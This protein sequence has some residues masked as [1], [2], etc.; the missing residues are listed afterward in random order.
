MGANLFLWIEAII[1]F[2][3]GL[4]LF[5]DFRKY[6]EGIF[7]SLSLVFFF[8]VIKSII[9][10]NIDFF[11]VF[12]VYEET[13]PGMGSYVTRVFKDLRPLYNLKEFMWQGIET[14]FLISLSFT[15]MIRRKSVDVENPRGLKAGMWVQIL[16]VTLIV[17]SVVGISASSHHG[18]KVKLELQKDQKQT[19]K[20]VKKVVVEQREI[21]ID[22]LTDMSVTKSLEEGKEYEY[23]VVRSYKSDNA[24]IE[25]VKGP[26]GKVM[27]VIWKIVLMILTLLSITSI[28]GYVANQ[29]AYFSRNKRLMFTF[30]F[31]QMAFYIFSTFVPFTANPNWFILDIIAIVLFATFGYKVHLQ[32]INNIEAQVES[33]G[34]ERDIIIDLMRDISGIVGSGNF[35]LDTV[36]KEIV[37]SSVKGSGARAG[38]V[39]IKDPL[40]NRLMVKYV[41]GLYPPTKPIKA[42]AGMAMNESII[43]EK[44]RSEKIMLGEGLLGEVAATGQAIYIPDV[45][46]DERYEQ[47]IKGHMNVT[48]FIAVPLKTT[49]DVFG[50][51]SVVD[52]GHSFLQG[53]LGLLETLGEQAAIT[54]KQIQMYQEILDKK[55]AEK[56]LGV[57]GEIQSS[58]IPH[59]FPE[60]DKYEMYAFSIPAKGVGGDY[61]DYIDFGNNKLAVTMFDVSGKGVPAALIMVMIR[62]ILRTIASL[63]EE[64]QAILTKLN[65]TIS[66]EI[67][68]DR[69][70]TG[71]Y[72]L[73]DAERGIMSYTNAGHGPLI[74]YR[75]KQDIFEFKD[76]DGM[77]VGIMSGVEYGQDYTTLEAGDVAILYTDGITEAMNETHEEYGMDRL[78][79]IVRANKRESAREISNRVLED[80]NKFVGN[81]PQHDDET[82]LIFKMR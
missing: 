48:S 2:F 67:V 39:L 70:A 19:D 31:I 26:A 35:E 6:R 66:E 10:D 57:A 58:L 64:T 77:P 80:V 81:A 71:F 62:S 8:V 32:Y 21:Q 28:F 16:L 1:A 50:V 46:K 45:S 3:V 54:I 56:E 17:G 73:F 23:R 5:L 44:F 29:L 33:L 74:L 61:Y 69:Y 13:A 63:D 68:E 38:T 51:L 76:T 72:L 34:K 15:I 18:Y 22:A 60:T 79:A 47:T 37:D 55:Q 52:D 75:A 11:N 7:K 4:L 82:L 20:V 53:D 43:V 41:K 30:I 42:I 40:T 65:N 49:E 25:I 14:I 12:Y 27:F 24:L 36:I 9:Y 59:S 78:Y